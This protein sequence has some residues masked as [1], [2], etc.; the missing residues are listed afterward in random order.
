MQV[1]HPQTFP[2]QNLT[3]RTGDTPS[4]IRLAVELPFCYTG[5][6]EEKDR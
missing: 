5:L 4:D 3:I 2:V 1:L 6:V